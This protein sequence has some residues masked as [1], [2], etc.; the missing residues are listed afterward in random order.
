MATFLFLVL[1]FAPFVT[2]FVVVGAAF[3]LARRV[4]TRL[5]R[6]GWHQPSATTCLLVAVMAGAAALGAY[7][8]GLWSGFYLLDPDQMCAARGLRGDRIVTRA[9]LP[10]SAQ[11]VTSDGVGSE[12]VPGWVNPVV[13]AGLTLFVLALVAGAHAAVR[14]RLPARL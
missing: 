8:W 7:T 4:H 9:T 13:F 3:A 1:T 5:P 12:L 10:V 11:C 14:R 6:T 2:P